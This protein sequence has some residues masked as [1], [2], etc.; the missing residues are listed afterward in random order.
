M[1]MV[2]ST[3]PEPSRFGS[4]DSR[5]AALAAR[6][7]SADGA[8][9]YAVRTTGVY[10]RPGCGSRLPKR[11]NVEFFDHAEAAARAGYRPCQRC[12]PN[13]E[14]PDQRRAAVI[15][16]ACRRLDQ[17]EDNSTLAQLAA[18]AGI[19]P[20]HFQRSFKAALGVTPKQY[21]ASRRLERLRARLRDDRTITGAIY[22][23]GFGSMGRAYHD[24]DARLGMTPTTYRKGGAGMTIEYAFARC[25][26]DWAIIA[27]TERGL[28]AIEF[29]D[30]RA[31]LLEQLTRH[32][33]KARIEKAPKH[34][35]DM[36]GK[37]VALVDSPK[38][39][40][41][42]PLDIRGT[43]FQQKVWRAL[44]AIAPGATASY[45][46]IARRIGM[47]KA[48]RAVAGACAANKLGVVV[49]C[50]R[51]LRSDGGL[52]GY[53]WGLERKRL[54]LEREAGRATPAK[55]GRRAK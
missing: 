41:D 30:D 35:S 10:C 13:A 53:R 7:A 26:L 11:G 52:G 5:W 19:S 55:A 34:F 33:P 23:A 16:Q 31:D 12:R 36:V 18:E 44:R 51:V 48:V 3:P 46:E 29:G 40:P 9:V 21:G 15:A 32:F 1:T 39:A 17:T 28:C 38:R 22:D 54:L 14:S 2:T 8:F 42:L 27:T 24:L 20:W 6:D 45:A 49:P 25:F 47:P 37:V 4:L 50:H 43:A